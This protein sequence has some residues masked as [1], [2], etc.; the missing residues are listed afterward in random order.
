MVAQRKQQSDDTPSRFAVEDAPLDTL[1][2]HERN[3][4]THPDDELE[5]IIE[6]IRTHGFYRNVVLARDGTILAGHGVVQAARKMGLSH[7]PAIRTDYA[8]DDPRAL[9]LLTGDNEIRHLAEV[10]DRALTE[11]LRELADMDDLLGTGYDDMMLANLTFVTRPASEIPDLDVAAQWAGMPEYDERGADK[12]QL[13][14]NFAT[15]ED[16]QEFYHL[17]GLSSDAILSRG[18]I[19]YIWWPKPYENDD[20]KSVYFMSGEDAISD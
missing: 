7:I 2:P 19:K 8:P 15:E 5:H 20:K 10:D 1:K 13:L 6:S 3:Y 9:K 4:Q 18:S 11:L 16:R 14:V 12:I 17:L